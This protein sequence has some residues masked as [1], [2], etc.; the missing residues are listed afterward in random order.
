MSPAAFTAASFVMTTCVKAVGLSF[1]S[2][3][4]GLCRDWSPRDIERAVT[5]DHLVDAQAP[6]P[7]FGEI[8]FD[9]LACPQTY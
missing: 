8:P 9:R 6:M 7:A 5:M 2:N 1:P 3:P 4:E